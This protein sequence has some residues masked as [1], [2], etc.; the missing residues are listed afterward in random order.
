MRHLFVLIFLAGYFSISANDLIPPKKEGNIIGIWVNDYDYAV[1][2]F[3]KEGDTYVGILIKPAKGH[4]LDKN[5]N[6]RKNEKLIKGLK[7]E[8]GIYVNGEL[9]IPILNKY[10]KCEIKSIHEDLLEQYIRF[11]ILKK[12]VTWSRVKE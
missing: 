3:K 6:P 11:G 12:T 2:E 5:G 4:E 8:N 7:Y 1:M 10:M 9:Y